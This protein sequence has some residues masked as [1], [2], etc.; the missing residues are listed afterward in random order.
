MK[1]YEAVEIITNCAKEYRA[2]LE[3]NN[4]LFIFGDK[5]RTEAFETIFLPRN[6]LHLTGVKLKSTCESSDFY[7]MCLKGQLSPSLFEMSAD[8][9]TDM[10]LC[11]LPQLMKIHR[12]AKMIGEY[13]QSKSFLVTEKIAGNVTACLGFVREE[14]YY[15]PNTALREDIRNVT[16]K[17]QQRILAIFKK[18][19]KAL[20]YTNLCYTA[21]NVKID[22]MKVPE[23]ISQKIDFNNIIFDFPVTSNCSCLMKQ[24]RPMDEVLMATEDAAA[25]SSIVERIKKTKDAQVKDQIKNEHPIPKRQHTR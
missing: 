12:T 16:V 18:N 9:T 24:N 8:G 13:D 17:P 25:S 21:K 1:K 20:Y 5:H 2:Y 14:G 6:F 22:T 23:S 19:S 10:K 11:V 7:E 3:D 4:F 15:I